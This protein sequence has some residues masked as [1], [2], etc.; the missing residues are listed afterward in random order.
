MNADGQTPRVGDT[1]PDFL[2]ATTGGQ[3]S[4]RQLAAG[5]KK[6][7]LTSQ[8]SYRYHPN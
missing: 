8:D 4:L 7:V 5:N 6:I 3:L 1:A 2:I